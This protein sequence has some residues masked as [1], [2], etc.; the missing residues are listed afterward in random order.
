MSRRDDVSK[1]YNPSQYIDKA[2]SVLFYVNFACAC[3]SCVLPDDVNQ[4]AIIIQALLAVLYVLLSVSDDGLFWYTAES[5][6]RKSAIENAFAV[7]L[8][9]L[10][11]DGYYNNNLAPST[12]KYALNAFESVF[13]SKSIAR[14]MDAKEAVK[15]ILAIIV[16]IAA[17]LEIK[18]G[19]IVLLVAQ[20]IF[21]ST[22]LIGAVGLW[23]YQMRLETLYREFYHECVTVGISK[24]EQVSM[25]LADTVEYEA[26]KAHYKIRLSSKLFQN[27][28]EE[29]SRQWAEIEGKIK[30]EIDI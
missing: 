28:N 15:S 23:L 5:Y 20:T 12:I 25:L 27:K 19:E 6:R 1:Y 9:N 4:I 8:T 13:F 7:D 29:L 24:N 2:T 21:S 22:F 3:I 16:F 18:N 30:I 14:C 10:Q 11:T 17:C 26:A